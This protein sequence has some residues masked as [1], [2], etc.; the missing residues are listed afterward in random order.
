MVF[1]KK[2]NYYQ[3]KIFDVIIIII[4]LLIIV[5]FLGLFTNAPAYLNDV[6]FY[7]R[8]YV[9]IF[10]IWRFNP[11]RN[12]DV[13]TNLDRKIAFNAGVFILTTT[14]LNT[15]IDEI[16]QKINNNRIVNIIRNDIDYFIRQYIF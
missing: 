2:F 15:Y 10:L 14:I 9:C 3:E 6:N 16:K 13:F 7:L 11:F 1:N 5:S 8:V 12:I 4:Y